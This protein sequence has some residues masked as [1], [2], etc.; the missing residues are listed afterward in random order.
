MANNADTKRDFTVGTDTVVGLGSFHKT[1]S[2]NEFGE[3]NQFA[4]K[5]LV[6]AT[7]GTAAFADVP[8]S[9]PV[10]GETNAPFVNPQAGLAHDRLTQHPVGFD[11][12]PA[13]TVLSIS[14]AAEMTEIYWM[15]KLRDVSLD[16][17]AT[18]PLVATAAAE[19]HDK[20]A[21]AV[22]DTGDAGHLKTGV[23]VPGAE[24]TLAAITPQ[25]V[26]R[27]G[28]PREEVGPLISQFFI[29]DINFGT[30]T[31][32]QKERPY[33]TGKNYLTEFGSWLHAQKLETAMTVWRIITPM[34]LK[35]TIMK[36]KTK[37]VISR[38]CAIW[39][40]S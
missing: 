15:A 6:D 37:F 11:M 32:D 29:R 12:P 39:R 3:V 18:D 34:K 23:D 8:K 5:D 31:I 22:A 27:L 7:E 9:M 33:K 21:L 28:L 25:N 4:F 16:K 2:H 1:L 36:T 24:G 14:T 13:P 30:Q 20:F 38:R 26:F 40:V 17:F 10:A 19:I 35:R